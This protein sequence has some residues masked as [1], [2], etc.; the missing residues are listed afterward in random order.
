MKV[1]KS[2]INANPNVGLYCYT[3]EKLCLVPMG[4]KKKQKKEFED[5][6]G[7]TVHEMTIAGTSLIGVFL[8]GK[9][10]VVLVPEIAYDHEIEALKSLGLKVVVLETELTALGNNILVSEKG[11]VV[12]PDYDDK[13]ISRISDSLGVEAK[14]GMIQEL[15]TVGSLAR[16]NRNMCLAGRDIK[17]FEKRFLS[18]ALKVEVETGTVNFGSPYISSGIICNSKGMIIGDASGGPEIVNADQSLK[19]EEE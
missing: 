17:E 13:V 4:L 8:T 16:C 7:V 1:I 12:N 19:I 14:P 18:S 6:L 3:T 11:C 10:D 5:V 15:K 2:N 9:D